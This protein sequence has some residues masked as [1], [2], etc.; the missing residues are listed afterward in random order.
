MMADTN[1]DQQQSGPK[2]SFLVSAIIIFVLKIIGGIFSLLHIKG[3]KTYSN[4]KADEQE[5]FSSMLDDM[6]QDLTKKNR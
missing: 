3:K 2:G 5:F 4:M 1:K 6:N